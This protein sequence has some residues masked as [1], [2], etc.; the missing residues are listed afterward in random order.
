MKEEKVWVFGDNVD[1]DVIIPAERLVTGDPK[2][3]AKYAFEKY[4]PDFAKKVKEGDVI[5]A[6]KN[7]GCGSSREHAPRALMGAGIK[8]V[9][10]ESYSSIF[11]RSSINIGLPVLKYLGSLLINEKDKI[12]FD[13]EEKLITNLDAEVVCK[14]EPIPEFLNNILDSGG[15]VEYTK[16]ELAKN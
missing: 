9:F 15:L 2:E 13:I 5:V 8:Y 11:Y 4:R 7:F 3:L 14:I 12:I 6:G 16:R 1:T 10:A